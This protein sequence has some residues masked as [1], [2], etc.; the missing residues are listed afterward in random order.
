MIT[1]KGAND[2]VT[3]P[4]TGTEKEDLTVTPTYAGV[5]DAAKSSVTQPA[6]SLEY[7]FDE[8]KRPAMLS[9]LCPC[10]DKW[11]I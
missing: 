11:C 10:L 5:T 3:G 2:D 6:K 1:P 8:S 4:S 9:Q 7:S